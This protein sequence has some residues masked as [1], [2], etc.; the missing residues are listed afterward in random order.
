M[1]TLVDPRPNILAS[2]PGGF[3]NGNKTKNTSLNKTNE[4]HT[5][6]IEK[7]KNKKIKTC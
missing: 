1:K 7:K 5:N 2:D 3:I 6:T 4:K